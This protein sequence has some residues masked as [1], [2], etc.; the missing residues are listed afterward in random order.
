MGNFSY[1]SSGVIYNGRYT[2]PSLIDTFDA[3]Q[4]IAVPLVDT[5][6]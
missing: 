6:E 3:Q 2:S 4:R 1:F 5:H